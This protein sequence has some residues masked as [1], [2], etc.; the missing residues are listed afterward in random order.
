MPISEIQKKLSNYKLFFS[1]NNFKNIL[2]VIFDSGIITDEVIDI[3]QNRLYEYGIDS[4]DRKLKTDASSNAGNVSS[5]YSDYTVKIKKKEITRQNQVFS[6]WDGTTNHVTLNDYNEFYSS[7]KGITNEDGFY[8][9]ADFIKDNLNTGKKSHIFQNFQN[10]FS[11]KKNFEEIILD[12]TKREKE[13]FI[14]I[15]LLPDYLK[16]LKTNFKN[17]T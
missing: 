6:S 9:E 13:I 10:M 5:V 12:L 16:L 17:K 2:K 3:I 8:L 1:F 7:F 11:S 14:K 4:L 15:I